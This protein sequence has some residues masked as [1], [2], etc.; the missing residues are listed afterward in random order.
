L[1]TLQLLWIN[2]LMDTFAAMALATEEPTEALLLQKPYSR[3]QSIFTP[4]MWRNI[5]CQSIFQFV[6]F[7]FFLFS[8][9][10]YPTD[11]YDFIDR[12]QSSDD[13]AWFEQM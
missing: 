12:A 10:F 11:T 8:V 13:C 4:V 6:L 2:I 5:I 3:N 1:G 9:R 7:N